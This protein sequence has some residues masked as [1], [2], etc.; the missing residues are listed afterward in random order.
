MKILIVEDEFNAREGLAALIK[1]I[2][3]KH[4]ICGKAADGE[5]GYEMAILLKPDLIFV[6]IQLP[7]LNGLQMIEKIVNA[8]YEPSFVILSGYA[9]FGYAQQ[10]IQYG[11]REYLLKPI[12]YEKLISVIQS[13]ENWQHIKKVNYG[14]KIISQD[15]IMKSILLDVKNDSTEALNF[16][17]N[18]VVPKEMYIVNLYYGKNTD[19]ANLIKTLDSFCKYYNFNN[20]LMSTLSTNKFVTVFINSE[21]EFSDMV[22]KIDYNLIFSLHKFEYKDL[23]VT[24]LPIK[25][26][27][28]LPEIL[29]EIKYLNSWAL[30]VGNDQVIYTERISNIKSESNNKVG[31]FDMQALSAIK[32]GNIDELMKANSGLLAFLRNNRFRPDQIRNICTRYAFSILV[33]YKEFNVDIY[34]KAQNMRLSDELNDSCTLQEIKECLDSLVYMYQ[35]STPIQHNVNSVLVRKA[36]NYIANSYMDKVS[37]EEIATQMNVSSEY[38]SHL[39]TKEVGISFS[40]YL[41]KYRIDVAK[42]LMFNSNFRIYEIGE[43]IGYKDPKYFCKMFKEVTGHSPKEYM[44]KQ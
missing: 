21:Y 43:K 36:M 29:D 13:M 41:K 11:V 8:K 30:T 35:D 40:D 17:K 9:E 3:P 16:I 32:S 22:K 18:T 28:Y 10:A 19:L 7:K 12:T 27:D 37:L 31:Q 15:E 5:E 33:C 34:E 23:T 38:L 14:K 6:D 25:E 4:E 26:I 44:I 24:L 2:S 1:K 42:K 20:Y 39:F